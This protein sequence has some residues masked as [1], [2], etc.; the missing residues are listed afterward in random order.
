MP[1]PAFEIRICNSCGLR[2]PLAITGPS[3]ATRCPACLGETRIILSRS[4]IAEPQH[5][6]PKS[7]SRKRGYS[8]LLDNIRSAWNVGSMLRTADGFGYSHAYICGITPSPDNEAV[9]KTSLG[10]ENSV[11][12][13]SHMDAVT[14]ATE[15]KSKGM[16]LIALEE[17]PCS[18]PITEISN[19]ILTSQTVL[20]V[21]NEIIGVD[22]H[23]LDLCDEI[24]HIPMYGEKRSFNVVIAFGIAAYALE[25]L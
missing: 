11:A 19:Q 20:I 17:H 6:F 8:V 24:Y 12:W 18:L 9:K 16:K 1:A 13:T 14:L 2:Y 23:L 4:L 25:T 10:A 22:P 15:L 7:A 21:G 3:P 5:A